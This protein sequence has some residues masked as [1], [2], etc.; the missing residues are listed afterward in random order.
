[1]FGSLLSILLLP[2]EAFTGFILL[3]LLAASLG[4]YLVNRKVGK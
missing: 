4:I 3:G 2:G 1:M